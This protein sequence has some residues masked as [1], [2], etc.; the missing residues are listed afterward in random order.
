MLQSI[1]PVYTLKEH[2]RYLSGISYPTE[3]RLNLEYYHG[4]TFVRY[5][6]TMFLL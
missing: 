5:I 6:R 3:Q 2:G 1:K 4:M